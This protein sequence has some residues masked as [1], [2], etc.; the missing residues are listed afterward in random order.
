MTSLSSVILCLPSRPE[1]TRVEHVIDAPLYG[2]L[3]ALPTN[4]RLGWKG[5][6]GTKTLAYYEHLQITDEKS[7]ITLG[8]GR[9]RT[10]QQGLMSVPISILSSSLI[11]LE[12]FLLADLFDAV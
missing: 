1:P 8:P 6:T 11:K 4:I 12:R 7:F 5:L 3:L 10:K 9:L 2:R